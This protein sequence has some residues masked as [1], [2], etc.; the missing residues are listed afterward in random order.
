MRTTGCET[1]MTTKQG[2]KQVLVDLY[3]NNQNFSH[4]FMTA[5]QCFSRLLFNSAGSSFKIDRRTIITMSRS[6]RRCLFFRK[7]SRKTLFNRFLL[8]ALDI[9]FFA[10]AKPSLG[11][12]PG[13]FATSIVIPASP[14]RKLFSNSNL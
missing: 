3:D 2:T 11:N 14:W 7:L 8:F 10:I 13:F 4:C 9:C 12:R 1:A 6:G 5:F